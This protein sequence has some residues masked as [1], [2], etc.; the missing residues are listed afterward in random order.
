M[1]TQDAYDF[2]KPNLASE[3]PVVFGDCLFVSFM[4]VLCSWNR[5]DSTCSDSDDVVK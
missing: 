1:I 2:Y 4:M 5:L 3:Y